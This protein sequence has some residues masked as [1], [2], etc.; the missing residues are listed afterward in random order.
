MQSTT[1]S[2]PGSPQRISLQRRLGDAATIRSSQQRVCLCTNGQGRQQHTTIPAKQAENTR[3]SVFHVW[4]TDQ[5][6]KRIEQATA[7]CLFDPF[8][9]V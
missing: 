1:A 4:L 8:A 3:Q 2:R 9:L 5:T 7:S 6:V